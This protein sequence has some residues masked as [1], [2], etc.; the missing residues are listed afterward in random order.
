MHSFETTSKIALQLNFIPNAI[1]LKI[2][3][4][5][6]LQEQ[7]IWHLLTS[8]VCSPENSGHEK[9]NFNV[10]DITVIKNIILLCRGY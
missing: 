3:Y 1:K 2:E 9:L 10:I 5:Q 8:L 6:V 7:N 4:Q